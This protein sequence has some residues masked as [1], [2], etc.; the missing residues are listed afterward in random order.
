MLDRSLKV[1]S[2][3]SSLP[4]TLAHVVCSPAPGRGW[5]I[6]IWLKMTENGAPDWRLFFFPLIPVYVMEI[7][8]SCLMPHLPYHFPPLSLSLYYLLV[9]RPFQFIPQIFILYHL[10]GLGWV[11]CWELGGPKVPSIFVQ[12]KTPTVNLVTEP[13][14]SG[15][16]RAARAAQ[17]R[18]PSSPWAESSLFGAPQ[19]FGF[20]PV[21]FKIWGLIYCVLSSKSLGKSLSP[22]V[23]S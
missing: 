8:S 2:R 7:A 15:F 18:S 16:P 22:S 13:D 12:S 9:F 17:P 10:G 19:S 3:G 4:A 1:S 14:L 20:Q 11:L 5:Q 21:L 23:C 6:S